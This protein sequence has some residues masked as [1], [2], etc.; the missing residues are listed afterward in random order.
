[1]SDRQTVNMSV[2]HGSLVINGHCVR[3]TL[4]LNVWPHQTGKG[5]TVK[6]EV[7][8]QVTDRIVA[9]LES[10]TKPWQ[11]SWT[12]GSPIVITGAM[13]RPLRSNGQAYRGMNV[14]NLWV[15]AQMR[16]LTSRHWLTYKG[17]QELGGQVRKGARAELAFFVGQ[18]TK[19]GE[20]EG[21]DDKTISFLKCYHVFNADE[22]DGLPLRFTNTVTAPVAPI[23]P[24]CP[25]AR[26]A[27]VDAF[28]AD[29]GVKLSHGGDRAFYMPST[30]AVRMP[31]LGAVQ[32]GRVLLRHAGA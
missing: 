12:A 7:Y 2:S 11:K 5:R 17:A 15:A 10:G 24:A 3:F 1:M 29:A 27:T 23:A 26:N 18:T 30:D 19:A 9:M 16:G 21:D 6:T 32:F 14:L 20:N 28:F 22:I 8:Q 4:S 25:H 13:Q 31:E